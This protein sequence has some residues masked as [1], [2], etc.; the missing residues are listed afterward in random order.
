MK[1][2]ILFIKMLAILSLMYGCQGQKNGVPSTNVEQTNYQVLSTSYVYK[3]VDASVD[4]PQK[5]LEIFKQELYNFIN[6]QV[7]E[8]NNT[9]EANKNIECHHGGIKYHT[10]SEQ[11]M[12]KTY[13]ACNENNSILSGDINVEVSSDNNL[14][15]LL[16]FSF[17]NTFSYNNMNILKSSHVTIEE[18][19][20]DNINRKIISARVNITGT[21][22]ISKNKHEVSNYQLMLIGE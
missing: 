4:A 21:F 11:S 8:S 20:Y 9:F 1:N 17:P 14:Q 3:S 19:N 7:N 6:Y 18:M 5:D 2:K 16:K 12:L 15:T 10:L 22:E 13:N